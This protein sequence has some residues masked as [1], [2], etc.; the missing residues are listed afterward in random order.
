VTLSARPG[1]GVKRT[2]AFT[3]SDSPTSK[4]YCHRPMIDH[5]SE[6]RPSNPTSTSDV[7]AERG[8]SFN[9][10]RWSSK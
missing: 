10:T 9:T 8:D 4:L 7:D 5:A 2:P 3:R 1:A 6:S